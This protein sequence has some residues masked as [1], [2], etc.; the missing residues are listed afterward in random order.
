MCIPNGDR[1]FHVSESGDIEKFIPR[2]P[3]SPDSGITE[4]AVWAITERL[5]HNYLLP[6]DC[7]RVT[8]YAK[9]DTSDADYRHFIQQGGAKHVVAIEWAWFSRLKNSHIWTYELPIETFSCAVSEAGYYISRTPVKPI[10]IQVPRCFQW[11][12]LV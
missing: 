12:A 10:K 9:P 1:L 11:V 2:V 6:R 7:P 3:P 4:P 5:L 8:Y